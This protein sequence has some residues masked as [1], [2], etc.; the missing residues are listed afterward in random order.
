MPTLATLEHRIRGLLLE[1]LHVEVPSPDTDLFESGVLDS[2]G[3]VEILLQLEGEFG[4]KVSLDDLE[5]DRFRSVGK[6][7]AFVASRMPSAEIG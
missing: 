2:L 1:T 5:I 3:F 4:I 7:A 6:I